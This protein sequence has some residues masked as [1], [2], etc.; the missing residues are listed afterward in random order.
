MRRLALLGA[1]GHGKVVADM[2][3]ALG[4]NEIFF[5]DDAWPSV[6][7]NSHW[8]VIG[9]TPKLLATANEYDGVI[10]TIGDCFIRWSKLLEL[11]NA[12]AILVSLVHPQA[13]IS[14]YAE[15]GLG[16]VVMAGAAINADASVGSACI[17]NTGATL[18]HDCVLSNAVHIS[19][20]AHL[21]GDVFVGQSSWIGVGASIRQGIKIGSFVTIG[22]GSVVVKDIGD[23]LMAYGNPAVT[24]PFTKS[25]SS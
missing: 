20:G 1:S 17:I 8:Q 16:S 22:A 11:Q 21:S 25:R 12:G 24:Y 15:L 19:P 5:F 9:D 14:K 13:F 7:K 18:D 6:N 4:W 2:A 10:I 3:E 23:S